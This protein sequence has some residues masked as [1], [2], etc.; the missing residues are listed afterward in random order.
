MQECAVSA[1]FRAFSVP[2]MGLE[3]SQSFDRLVQDTHLGA[4]ARTR[5]FSQYRLNW[6]GS[7]WQLERLPHRPFIQAPE[8]N[9]LVG[10]VLREFEPLEVDP[11]AVVQAAARAAG[12]STTIDWH[13]NVHQIR[14]SAEPSRSVRVVPEGL[15][16]DGHELAALLIVNRRDIVEGVTKLVRQDSGETDFEGIIQS[17]QG[18]VFDD[19]VYLHDTTPILSCGAAGR[20]DMFIVVFNRW[21]NARYGDQHEWQSQQGADA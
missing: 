14:V 3:E 10:G 8:H 11:T 12:L 9:K 1:G 13:S 16:Q 2:R 7:A 4:Q 17:G 20:R 19:Q 6:R 5:R 21:Q 15:H 18:I